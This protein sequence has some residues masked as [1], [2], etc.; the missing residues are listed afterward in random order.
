MSIRA[1]EVFHER[2]D[3]CAR[4]LRADMIDFTR[5]LVAVASENPPG[6]AYPECLR[7][8]ESR[9]RA[10]GMPY[11]R[12]P[13]RPP[14]GV[15]DTSGA[16]VLVSR[17]GSG[18]RTLYF[19]GHYDVVPMTTPGQCTPILRGKSLFGRGAADMKSGLASML[20]A[21]VALRRVGVPLDGVIA[22]V[23]VPDEETGGQRGSGFLET[24]KRLGTNGIGMLTPEPTSGVIWNANR[25]AVTV[26]VTVHGR[27]AHVGLLH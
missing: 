12:V 4:T 8:I 26:S 14:R 2:L 9:L 1:T 19:S 3:A 16:V 13:Y 20:Y 22:L 24:T 18:K 11:E 6:S 23:F 25:G 10:L 27:E 15:R 7:V 5:E 17:I 21:A